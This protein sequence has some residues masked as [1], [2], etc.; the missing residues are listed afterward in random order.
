MDTVFTHV[1]VVFSHFEL[2]TDFFGK[3][4]IFWYGWQAYLYFLVLIG[5]LASVVSIYYYLK[6]I[7]LLMTRRNQELTPYVRH[8]SVSVLP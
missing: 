5:L 2:Y 4:Y 1:W 8:G 6:V 3:L 7:K